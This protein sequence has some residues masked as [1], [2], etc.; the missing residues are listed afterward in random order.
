MTPTSEQVT[1][2]ASELHRKFDHVRGMAARIDRGA[3]LAMAGDVRHGHSGYLVLSSANDGTGYPISHHGYC[4]C[5][6]ANN[7]SS[8]HGPLIVRSIPACK[9]NIAYNIH[10]RTLCEAIAARTLGPGSDYGNRQ[11]QYS[12]PNTFLLLMPPGS[13]AK[14]SLWSDRL[15]RLGFV[16]W[17]TPLNAWIPAS[18]KDMIAIEEWLD[19]ANDLPVNTLA[20]L[21][22]L[23]TL[24]HYDDLHADE[25]RPTMSYQQFS[26]YLDTGE[27]PCVQELDQ[28]LTH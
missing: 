3:A 28:A 27:L 14:T 18:P 15:G 25:W 22:T 20:D 10:F 12:A 4:S 5:P 23:H 7:P 6:D 19:Q 2:L 11:R 16:A 24:S 13:G 21:A 1:R 9:H 8:K 26:R 17:S